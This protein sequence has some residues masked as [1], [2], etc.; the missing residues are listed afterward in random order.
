MRN[1]NNANVEEILKEM[2]ENFRKFGI[3]EKTQK[4]LES[5]Q[6]EQIIKAGYEELKKLLTRHLENAMPE[7]KAVAERLCA[8]TEENYVAYKKDVVNNFKINQVKVF[9]IIKDFSGVEE[10]KLVFQRAYEKGNEKSVAEVLNVIAKE[11]ASTISMKVL[12]KI[13]QEYVPT[14][15][16]EELVDFLKFMTGG[17]PL[18][19]IQ[20]VFPDFFDDLEDETEE[21]DE[22]AETEEASS[23]N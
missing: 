14:G 8:D 6:A 19:P 13:Y 1:V 20:G 22:T 16:P 21:S 3:Y 17:R 9:D 23:E 11:V 15:M 7:V 2:E 18:I 12:E 4:F 10:A 5:E